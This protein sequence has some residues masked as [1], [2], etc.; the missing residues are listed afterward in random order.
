MRLYQSPTTFVEKTHQYFNVDGKELSGIT[1]AIKRVLFPDKY[2]DVDPAILQMA[3]SYGTSVHTDIQ[4]W[5]N[6]PNMPFFTEEGE[7]Y[8]NIR[9]EGLTFIADEYLVSNETTHASKIDLVFT[10]DNKSV[11]LADIKCNANLDKEYL[12]WQLSTY[13]FLFE[14]Q[15]PKIKVKKIL[16]VW[17]P[18]RDKYPDKEPQ[19]VELERLADKEVEDFLQKD[20]DGEMMPQATVQNLPAELSNVLAAVGVVLQEKVRVDEEVK[21]LKEQILVLCEKYG[22]KKWDNDVFSLTY[23]APTTSSKVD[24]ALLKK[25]Y[26]DIAK[27]VTKQTSVKSSIRL[28]L[29]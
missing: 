17:L 24:S 20:I 29:K 15:N 23:V 16:G 3:A 18:R 11:I 5:E 7:V 4:S 9:P 26:P 6:D 12:R 27:E 1:A 2:K 8:K 22:I 21:V 13:A 25:T 19:F 14:K 28:T 10:E